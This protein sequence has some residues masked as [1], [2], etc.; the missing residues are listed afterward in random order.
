[1]LKGVSKSKEVAERS[2]NNVKFRKL[3]LVGGR[4]TREASARYGPSTR[5]AS[6]DFNYCLTSLFLLCLFGPRFS[7]FYFTLLSLVF[8][9]ANTKAEV[10]R[11]AEPRKLICL[12]RRCLHK[13]RRSPNR[14]ECSYF[15]NLFSSL[16]SKWHVWILL[17]MFGRRNLGL[18]LHRFT[19]FRVFI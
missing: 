16:H 18:G 1:M 12:A 19:L 5:G 14:I 15:E 2:Q 7:I 10:R 4:R 6:Y 11:A 17:H 9:R 3:V 13:S 8:A